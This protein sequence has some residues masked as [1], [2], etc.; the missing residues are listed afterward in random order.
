MNIIKSLIVL[1]V[2]LF[3]IV[4]QGQ[5]FEGKIV[6][7]DYYESKTPTVSN[8]EWDEILG[9]KHE[10]Y[11]KNGD[12]K[13]FYNGSTSRALRWS[14]YINE[15]NKIYG[16]KANTDTILWSDAS[17]KSE[18]LLDV[19]LNKEVTEILGYKCDEIILITKNGSAK[20]YFNKK[21]S[22][23]PKYFVNHKFGHWYDFIS[24]SNSMILK[25]IIENGA[26]I[27]YSEATEIKEM[28]MEDEFFK[29]PPNSKTKENAH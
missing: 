6:Y 2:T 9:S 15:D 28:S 29:L 21:F 10:F 11:I 26:F 8:K 13:V 23:D 20:Y 18:I 27:S 5:L 4:A 25:S 12:Y 7:N 22:V 24:R 16:K 14:L 1:A 17:L 19:I 3:A